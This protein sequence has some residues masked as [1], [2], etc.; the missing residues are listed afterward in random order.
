MNLYPDET[1]VIARCTSAADGA[2]QLQKHGEHYELVSNGTFLMATYNGTTEELMV[3]AALRACPRSAVTVLVGGLG[4]GRSAAAA[5]ADKRV[6]RVDVVEVEPAIVAW[7][8]TYLRDFNGGLLDNPAVRLHVQNLL[9]YVTSEGCPQYG[10][11]ALDIDNGPDWTVT[12]ANA[13]LY[14]G[15]GVERLK[16]LL[17]PGGVLSVWS[18]F[19]VPWY[20]SLLKSKFA[21]VEWVTAGDEDGAYIAH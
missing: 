5:T 4:F 6:N 2:L 1:R 16:A 11:V 17:Q 7:N 15:A 19:A 13:W 10:L 9:D 20:E 18:A 3:T 12:E 21:Q 8:Q 14:T